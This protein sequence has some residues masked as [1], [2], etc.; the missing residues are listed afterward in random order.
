LSD[1]NT[2]NNRDSETATGA[3]A[4]NAIPAVEGWFTIGDPSTGAKP[5]LIGTLCKES[6]TYF[7]PPERTMSR[8]PGHPDSELVEVELSRTG[9]IW[10]Y[11]DA[12]YQPPPPYVPVD[13]PHVP[14]AIAAVELEKEKMVVL[15]QVARGYTVDDLKVGMEMELVIETLSAHTDESGAEVEQLIWKWKPTDASATPPSSAG[16]AG[17]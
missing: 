9:R 6:G 15:G 12:Q 13:D 14:F 5:A 11:T 10:S 3:A 17:Q 2:T 16:E 4:T 7:F 1:S 8:V